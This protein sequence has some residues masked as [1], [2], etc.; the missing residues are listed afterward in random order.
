MALAGLLATLALGTLAHALLTSIRRRRRELA[1]LKTLGFVGGQVRSAVRWQSL[2]MTGIAAV[3]GVPAGIASGRWLW[4]LFAF[5]TV[6]LRR[7]NVPLREIFGAA[8]KT[9]DDFIMDVVIAIAFWFVAVLVLGILGVAFLGSP[10]SGRTF[11]HGHTYT[12]N[13]LSCD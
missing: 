11:F 12:A 1:V 2:T 7:R 4:L 9:F 13:P 5:V 8:W 10:A 6:G 3:V